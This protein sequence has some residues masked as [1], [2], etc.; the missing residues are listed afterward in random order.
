MRDPLISLGAVCVCGHKA[1]FTV[2]TMNAN[3]RTI[4]ARRSWDGDGEGDGD[5]GVCTAVQTT[6][7]ANVAQGG[8]NPP[9]PLP[10][11][12]KSSV[13]NVRGSVPPLGP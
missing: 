10:Q 12:S 9:Q 13:S 1:I 5:R 11:P 8:H 3:D 7:R 6:S 2:V 4:R